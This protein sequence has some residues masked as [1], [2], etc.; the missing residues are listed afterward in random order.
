MTDKGHLSVRLE[1]IADMV[2]TGRR[3]VDIGCDHAYVPI[4]LVETGR[5][6]GA[7]AA[8]VRMEPLRR[9]EEHIRERGLSGRI[10]TRLSDG[11]SAIG[12]GEADSAI[13]AGMGGMLI[14]RIL[15]DGRKLLPSLNELIIEP[16]S[17]ADEVRRVLTEGDGTGVMFEIADER[18]VVDRMKYYPIIRAV[19]I[20]PANPEDDRKK[21]HR[22]RLSKTELLY[23]PV[24]LER[25]DPVLLNYLGKR[26][27]KLTEI[28]QALRLSGK[29]E[30]ERTGR[31]YREIKE[32]IACCEAALNVYEMQ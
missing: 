32:E 5:I 18:L 8:D 4:R 30:N 24:L 17:D 6:D 28:E 10:A 1:T 27:K 2:R 12:E 23:G 7:I 11:F 26:R 29:E 13:I 20:E 15:T 31:R 16:Q 3:P 25:R 21:F 22:Q 19:P 9:A 14:C